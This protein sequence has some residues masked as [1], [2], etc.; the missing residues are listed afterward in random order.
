MHHLRLAEARAQASPVEFAEELAVLPGSL[1]DVFACL[2]RYAEAVDAMRLSKSRSISLFGR[3]SPQVIAVCGRL[4]RALI[5]LEDYTGAAEQLREAEVICEQ[6]GWKDLEGGAVH[7]HFGELAAKQGRLQDALA[8]FERCL[9]IQRR[10]YPDGHPYMALVTR[11]ISIVQSALGMTDEARLSQKAADQSFRRS[12]VHCA[13]P[14]C[15]LQQRPDGG[16]LDQCAGCLRTH[17]CSLACQTA[18]W[19]RK[20]ATRRSVRRW[21]RRGG[22][23]QWL[24]DDPRHAP[25]TLDLSFIACVRICTGTGIRIRVN[26]RIY[27]RARAHAIATLIARDREKLNAHAHAQANPVPSK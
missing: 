25:R 7:A 10:F 24:C 27:T 11:N 5:S 16:P 6:R 3:R 17:Y 4:A 20:G 19:K 9:A 12:Q 23:R 8:R 18:D 2:G 21:R 22:R 14:G 1:G 26:M 15:N 13:G